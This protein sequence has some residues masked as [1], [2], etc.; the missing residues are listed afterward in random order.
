[1]AT[2]CFQVIEKTIAKTQ[3]YIYINNHAHATVF[4][5]HIFRVHVTL[6][7]MPGFEF[8]CPNTN[9]LQTNIL[10]TSSHFSLPN[11]YQMM[12]IS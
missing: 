10:H 7:I 1:M 6:K 3:I 5:K 4:F 11:L 8:S 12:N 2:T 9:T